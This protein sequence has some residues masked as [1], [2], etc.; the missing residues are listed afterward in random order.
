MANI[1]HSLRCITNK[2]EKMSHFRT[3]PCL[4]KIVLAFWI[5]NIVRIISSSRMLNFSVTFKFNLEKIIYM[6]SPHF[7][8]YVLYFI[9]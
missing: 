3:L 5:S 1:F 4:K 8:L 2:L 6:I 9:V 7:F